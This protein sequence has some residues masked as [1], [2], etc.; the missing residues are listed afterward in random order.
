MTLQAEVGQRKSAGPAD[1]FPQSESSFEAALSEMI[2]NLWKAAHGK[3]PEGFRAI[4][5]NILWADEM[6]SCLFGTID[7]WEKGMTRRK[8]IY[9]SEHLRLPAAKDWDNFQLPTVGGTVFS[10]LP[11]LSFCQLLDE[12]VEDTAEASGDTRMTEKHYAHWAP[13]YIAQTIRANFP[14]LN[15]ASESQVVPLRR[16]V[17]T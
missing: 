4:A 6:G 11:L 17:A 5:V 16:R 10:P 9:A 12:G 8:K 15:L 14:V 1:I 2:R 7:Q 3:S 13:S